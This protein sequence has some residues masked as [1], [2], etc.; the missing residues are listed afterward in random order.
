M[1]RT[2]QIILGL[3]I[4]YFLY[5]ALLTGAVLTGLLTSTPNP[6][7]HREESV[8]LS[9]AGLRLSRGYEAD[10]LTGQLRERTVVGSRTLS[11]NTQVNG[12]PHV[13]HHGELQP[14]AYN[15]RQHMTE[16]PLGPARFES[17]LWTMMILV[18]LYIL[19]IIYLSYELFRF[20][21]TAGREQ[22]F[23]RDNRMRLRLFGAFLMATW[24]LRNLLAHFDILLMEH[25]T[26]TTG[27][28]RQSRSE[29]TGFPEMLIAGLLMFIIAEAFSKGQKLQ[30]EQ[31]LTI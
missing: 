25:L 1:I 14:V 13:S 8:W 10:S 16:V 17:V 15:A 29:G 4:L 11:L 18:I 3:I 28:V 12:I 23:N 5:L 24:F 20:A 7:S 6:G 22:F 21:S 27:F 26:D 2:L 30:T 9:P 31:D 19:F